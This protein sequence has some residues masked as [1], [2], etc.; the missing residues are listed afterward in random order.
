MDRLRVMVAD[1]HGDMRNALVSI[2]NRA[3]EIAGT[4]EDGQALVDAAL[5]LHPD[6]IVSD[7]SMPRFT[8][9]EAMQELN[10]RGHNIPFVFVSAGENI[11][12]ERA[13]FVSKHHAYGKLVAAVHAA[14]AG[15]ACVSH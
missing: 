14:A 2:L 1:D 4:A 5:A 15:K 9:P 6:V 10:A 12:G 3:F 11:I 13:P 8:G 7:I